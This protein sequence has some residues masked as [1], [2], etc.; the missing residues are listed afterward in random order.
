[1]SIGVGALLA[2]HIKD[3]RNIT[4]AEWADPLVAALYDALD[5]EEWDLA[6]AEA[7]AKAVDAGRVITGPGAHRDGQQLRRR[8]KLVSE[9]RTR[10]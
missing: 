1:M 7:T 2:R 6:R 8:M 10:K 3:P 9:D 5:P 4:P